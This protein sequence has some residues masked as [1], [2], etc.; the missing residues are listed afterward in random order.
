MIGRKK[1]I[2]FY[3]KSINKNSYLVY[4]RKKTDLKYQ[5]FLFIIFFS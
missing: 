1:L 3:E 5:K 2:F 4:I